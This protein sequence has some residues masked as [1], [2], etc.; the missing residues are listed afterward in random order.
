MSYRLLAVVF[1]ATVIFPITAVSQA[2]DS[3]SF[4]GLVANPGGDP[5][6]DTL[7]ITTTFYKGG[8][9]GYSQLHMDV[10][11]QDGLFNLL[12]GPVDT[13]L[14]DQ[15]IELGVTIDTDPEMSPRIALQSAPFALGLRGLYA[16]KVGDAETS[17]YNVI[18]GW[19]GNS[20][21]SNVLGATIGGGGA[22]FTSAGDFSNT[23]SGNFGTI[24]GGFGNS[25]PL[26]QGTVGGGS[27][28]TAS[29][30]GFVGGGTGNFATGGN[31]VVAGG[32][33]NTADNEGTSIGGGH[34]NSA[35]AERATVGGGE[36]NEATDMYSTVSGGQSNLASGLYATVPG[37][38]EN[39]AGG[40][41]SFAAGRRAKALHNFTF[42][43]ND[44]SFSPT[45]GDSLVSSDINQF[46]VKATGGVWFFSNSDTSAGVQLP[47]NM[48]SWMTISSADA[49]AD[50][51]PMDSRE[52]L[53]KL[54]SIPIQ[55][56]R[57]KTEDEGMRHLGPTAQDFYDAFGLGPS[58]RGIATVD[59][60]GVAMAAI[61]GLYEILREQHEEIERLKE[62]VNTTVSRR[63]E[64]R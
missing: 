44:G 34:N 10:P 55:T 22:S 11:I 35:T 40:Q 59:A 42:V 62:L 58:R 54:A 56:W 24:G 1:L 29:L 18:G 43:W 20:V 33:H 15:P 30:R 3:I 32:F 5:I 9:A 7:D 46:L 61:Q 39:R 50:F 47:P 4:Q 49:K 63:L 41:Y 27:N 36:L 23:V 16:L 38:Q 13:V 17:T 26:F 60:D 14:F 31:S 45:V 53:E 51:A 8:L 37:G 25:V 64:D 48:G 57:Y 19:P 52:V 2:P 21:G 6:N 28:N 12:I